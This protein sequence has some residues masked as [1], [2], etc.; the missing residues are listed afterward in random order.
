[1]LQ[2]ALGRSLQAAKG[3]A[4]PEAEQVYARVRELC[5]QA[6][7]T[8]ALLS[9]LGGLRTF[10]LV[11]AELRTARELAEHFL[12]LAQRLPD[13][14]RGVAHSHL[15]HTILHLGELVAARTHLEHG[16]ILCDSSYP[17]IR[18]LTGG[19]DPKNSCLSWVPRVL[20]L[21]G[22]PDQALQRSNEAITHARELAHPYSLLNALSYSA[23][24]HR[25]CGEV[26]TARE[27]EEACLALATDQG[28]AQFVANRT[29]NRGL[30]LIAQ[31][32]AEEGRVQ[33]QQGLAAYQATGARA[34]L[35]YYLAQ[36][37]EVYGRIGQPI[38]GLVAIA[39]ALAQ[40]DDT[41]ERWWEAELYRLKGALLLVQEDPRP[42]WAEAEQCFQQALA[43]ACGQQAKS[44]ELRAAISLSRLWQR[45]GRREAAH[46]LLADVYQWFTEG[47]D[48]ADLKE[49]RALLEEQQFP[50][51]DKI[52]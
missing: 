47:F 23:D 15:G 31:G 14:I 26:T 37:A 49:A 35:P 21:L 43:V 20:W 8:P 33:A 12:R 6:G 5:Q 7:D 9:V 50:E 22:Y 45:Q 24:C 11:R 36:L 32:Q 17:A 25:L 39:E 28:A 38:E 29:F 46:Q 48:T 40:V 44:L 3:Y 1:M 41:D 4:S 52:Q 16:I 10:Y 30:W 13:P 2:N 42:K 19:L 34:R 51:G 27:Q 18:L